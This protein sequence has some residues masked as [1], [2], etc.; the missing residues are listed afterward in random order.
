MRIINRHFTNLLEGY[1]RIMDYQR[2][3]EDLLVKERE[4]LRGLNAER[5]AAY[6]AQL[7]HHRQKVEQIEAYYA[8]ACDAWEK[9]EQPGRQVYERKLVAWRRRLDRAVRRLDAL[10][11][12]EREALA[13][14][15]ARLAH[16]RDA[17][18]YLVTL[19]FTLIAEVYFGARI[20]SGQEAVERL[21]T[22]RNLVHATPEPPY[23]PLTPKPP[24]PALP[25]EPEKPQSLPLP[26]SRS[27]MVEDWWTFL[28]DSPPWV[29]NEERDHPG[30]VGEMAMLDALEQRLDETFIAIH[31][32]LVHPRH[33]GDIVVLGGNG[34][35][36]LECKHV[37]GRVRYDGQSWAHEKLSRVD[38]RGA[39]SEMEWRP[40][41]GEV[42]NPSEQWEDQS[43]SIKKTLTMHVRRDRMP[44][45]TGGIVFT[46]DDTELDIRDCLIGWGK[47]ADWVERIAE[48]PVDLRYTE[49]DLASVVC[50]NIRALCKRARLELSE[51]EDH[52]LE[53]W[54][55]SGLDDMDSAV[56]SPEA[57][58][59]QTAEAAAPAEAAPMDETQPTATA[60]EPEVPAA[61]D[62]APGE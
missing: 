60:T 45:V 58:E 50:A 57:G 30:L 41:Q 42:F 39:R 5:D 59:H 17:G 38:G 47:I 10:L 55:T 61:E 49:R 15:E 51:Y 46:I 20:R 2:Q 44:P 21:R 11:A 34:V 1:D 22:R 16:A 36:L 31:G 19:P 7:G 43:R 62:P 14:D 40:K 29:Q 53:E 48:M 24:H 32:V 56:E 12:Q 6:R 3:F 9:S 13:E 37:S 54:I 33:D 23:K 8:R 28:Q 35:W 52:L 18:K 27:S 26:E 25:K 4:R